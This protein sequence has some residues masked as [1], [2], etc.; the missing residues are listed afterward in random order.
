MRILYLSP[1]GVLGGA[2]RVLLS[3]MAA[4]RQARPEACPH[5]LALGD[6]PLPERAARDGL[7]TTLL[8]LP[9]ALRALGDSQLAGGGPARKW[10]AL[11]CRT[12]RAAPAGWA[13]LDRLRRRVRQAAPDLIHSNGIKTHLLLRLAGVRPAP[14]V[15]HAPDFYR[16]RPVVRRLLRW[17][18]RGVSGAL[19]VSQ[20]V[21][22][23]LA[24]A[25]PGLPIRVVRNTVDVGTFAPGEA[26]GE[27][28]DAAAGWPAPPGPVVRVGLVATY[29]RWKGQDLFLEAVARL[30]D[31]PFPTPVRFY[32]VGGPIYGTYGSQFTE[33]ELRGLARDLG[34]ADRVGFV[35]FREDPAAAF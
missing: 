13:Y 3:V 15:W 16:A 5:L 2:E 25:L 31:S 32:L 22:D 11:L 6:G 4:V 28:L 7:P 23:D 24:A 27:W 29:A 14:V 34:V 18:R 9:P 20:A 1:T 26:T 35:G 10:G 8:P 17:A 33:A 19:A 12:L 21:A 30:R